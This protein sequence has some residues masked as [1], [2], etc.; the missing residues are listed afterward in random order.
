MPLNS[1]TQFVVDLFSGNGFAGSALGTSAVT[2]TLD[3]TAGFYQ[4]NFSSRIGLTAGEKY[5]LR[6]R[7]INSLLMGQFI[8]S[9][10]YIGGQSFNGAGQAEGGTDLRFFE[11]IGSVVAVPEPGTWAMMLLGFAAIGSALR[12]RRTTERS[13]KDRSVLAHG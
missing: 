12:T 13:R 5:T 4:A 6:V 1:S 9:D 11:G 3:G 10:H 2:T 7:G 8:A